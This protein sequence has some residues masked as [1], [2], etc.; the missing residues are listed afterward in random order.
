VTLTIFGWRNTRPSTELI[1]YSMCGFNFCRL[2]WPGKSSLTLFVKMNFKSRV[3]SIIFTATLVVASAR[4]WAGADASSFTARS[5]P[6]WLRDGVVYEIFPRDFSPAGNLQG[7]TAKL[8]QLYQLGVTILWIMPIQP[9]GKEHRKGGYG[10]PY[11]IQNYYAVNPDYGTLQDF[12]NL[13]AAAHERGMKVIMDLVADHTSWDSV[14]M[15]HPG[16]YRHGPDGKIVS[17]VPA[18]TDVA[19]LNYANPKLRAYMLKMMEY[20]V[21]TCGIDGFRC[22]AASMVPLSFW[23]EARAAIAKIEPNFLWLAEASEPRLLVKAFDIDYDWPLMASLN[24]VIMNSAPASDLEATWQKMRREFP[25]G[26]LHMQIS[27]DHDEPRAVARF[28][29]YGALAA[30]AMMFTLNG[31]PMLYN[32]MEVGDATESGTPALFYKLTIFWHPGGRPPEREIYHSLIHLRKQYAG[33]FCN[34][35]VTWLTN[36]HENDVVTFMRQDIT[37]QFVVLINFSNRALT[38]KVEVK[39]GDDFKPMHIP[40]L[41]DRP[42]GSLSR[43][44]LNG[45]GW[46]IF[47]RPVALLD[48]KAGDSTD[49]N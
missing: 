41:H 12:K 16:F 7:V 15:K 40:G 38:G 23:L 35:Q 19:G 3:F 37:N 24:N 28:G 43:F 13:V 21:R 34:N 45:F 18:W 4:A 49:K 22:D 36:S 42:V 32:G 27:D 46:R 39:N 6:T 14:M 17:P 10:S 2:G 47:H 5:S 29:I 26:A 44:H 1:T 48:P 30:S 8:D 20:W 31:V 33:C 11:S 9:I 25:K